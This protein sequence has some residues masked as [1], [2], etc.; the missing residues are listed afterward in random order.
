MVF[1]ASAHRCPRSPDGASYGQPV[2]VIVPTAGGDAEEIERFWMIQVSRAPL[3]HRR[4]DQGLLGRQRCRPEP[5]FRGKAVPEH[6]MW[7]QNQFHQY[8]RHEVVPAI[9]TDCR[10][11]ED[12]PDLGDRRIHRRVPFGGDWSVRFPDVFTRALAMSGTYDLMRFVE[13]DHVHPRLLGIITATLCADARWPA[14]R[15]PPPSIYR[16][17]LRRRALGEHGRK[18]AHGSCARQPRHSESSRPVGPGVGPRLDHVAGKASG[19]SID[20]WTS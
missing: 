9:R 10:I 15:G 18:L 13:T 6:R 7:L 19:L 4:S 14:S 2:L 3:L 5:G 17:R 16:A 8:I 20:D 1:G 11:A 12:I